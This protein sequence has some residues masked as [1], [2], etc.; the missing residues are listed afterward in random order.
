MTSFHA[1]MIDETQCE[2][3]V[4][5]EAESEGMAYDYLHVNYPESSVATLEVVGSNARQTYF[6]RRAQ[7]IYDD[8]MNDNFYPDDMYGQW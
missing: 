5:F 6:Q 1:C 2:F 8:E 3:G 7:M 4:T